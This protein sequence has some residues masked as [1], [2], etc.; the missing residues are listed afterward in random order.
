MVRDSKILH[1]MEH[2]DD[3]H[4]AVETQ[5]RDRLEAESLPCFAVL[6]PRPRQVVALVAFDYLE[7][8]VIEEPK[9]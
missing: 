1:G 7:L 3:N 2:T 4:V 8:V 5:H 6:L 9:D